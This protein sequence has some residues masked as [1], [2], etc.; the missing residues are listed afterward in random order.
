MGGGTICA[1]D[2]EKRIEKL[3]QRM[4]RLYNEDPLDP[5]VVKVSQS[6]DELL[7]ER[8]NQLTHQ[9]ERRL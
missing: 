6:I 2:L 7:N 4:Y 9:K 3:R 1:K 8:R 5:Q